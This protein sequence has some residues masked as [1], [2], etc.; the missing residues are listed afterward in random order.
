MWQAST[1]AESFLRKAKQQSSHHDVIQSLIQAVDELTREVK[2]LDNE[3][4]RVQ[5][6]V[7][8]RRRY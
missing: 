3:V 1:R 6:E 8:F 4:R 7:Q 5:R 2:R